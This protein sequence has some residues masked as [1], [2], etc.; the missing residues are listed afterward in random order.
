MFRPNL[1]ANYFIKKSLDSGTP[2]TPMKLLKLV[3]IAHGYY[4]AITGDD[5]INEAVQAWKFGPVIPSVYH[6]FK[7][8]GNDRVTATV[9]YDT[10]AWSTSP[11]EK[12]S[13]VSDL[14]I[15]P[16]NA[17]L[18]LDKIWDIYG[19]MDGIQLS[20]LTH[21]PDTPWDQIWKLYGE[22]GNRHVPIPNELIKSH[23]K[24]LLQ[25]QLENA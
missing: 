20:N 1:I 5:L 23:Y 17:K 25:P 13:Q 22:K 7:I 3:Y 19:K 15:L 12:G 24:Q 9:D 18:L 2:V 6:K 10:P 11:F 21:Q 16:V 14:S 8:Y 4:L